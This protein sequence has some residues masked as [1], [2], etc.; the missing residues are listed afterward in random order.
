MRLYYRAVT[1]DGK[2]IRGL[3]EAKDVQEAANY[4]HQHQL[5]PV[6]IIPETKAGISRHIP[7]LHRVK[8]SDVIFFTRQLA[9]M[10]TSGLT[11]LQALTVLKNQMQNLAMAEIVQG[12]ISD[13]EDGLMLS[14]SLEKYPRAFSPIYVALIKTAE[15]SGLLDKIMTRLAEN[16]EKKEELVHTIRGALLYPVIVVVMMIL[17][18]IVMMI[19]VIPQL[20]VLY[21]NLSLQ[22]P[23]STEIVI[24]SSTFLTNYWY[25]AITL[26]V[27]VIYSVRNWYRKPGGRKTVD[28]YLLKL[29]IFGR[30]L[31]DSMMAE[32]ARTLSLLI[33][34][35]SL[36]VDSLLKSSEV[37]GNIIYKDA[38]G[39]VA[40]RVEK[41]ISI[42]DAMAATPLFPPMIVEMVKIGE[43]TGKLDSSLMKASEYFEREVEE[44]VKVMT[45]LMEPIIMVLLALG[46]GFLIISII[47]PIYNLISNIS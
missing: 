6:Q 24:G 32:F 38:I 2:T 34:S 41:G 26:L 5:V 31:Q 40:R 17:V 42:G 12:I 3:I 35:G 18:M 30:L 33:N 19:Y 36:V 14:K 13:I 45:T 28:K 23:V 21:G 4:L 37:V 10:I 44:K 47:T 27:V 25:I 39:L 16:L 7:F 9:S 1:Q 29:P 46:V 20:T 43:Q 11:L 8:T 22:L 15:S